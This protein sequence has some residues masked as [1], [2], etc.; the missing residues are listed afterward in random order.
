[1]PLNGRLRAVLD[2][3]V[4][5]DL[6]L[7]DDARVRPLREAIETRGLQVVRSDACDAEFALVLA[8][9]QFGLD[10][11]T[12]EAL[13]ARFRRF[14][15]TVLPQVPAPLASADPD[16]QKFLDAAFAA[17]ADLLL[18]RDKAL[19]RLARRA[20]ALGLRIAEPAPPMSYDP[21]R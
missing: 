10:G 16:D 3:N 20:A 9:E 18:T 12:R 15:A 7:F 19:L 1:M 5:L 4:L 6:W 8:R 2:T 11:P 21:P 13:L 14:G 17:R